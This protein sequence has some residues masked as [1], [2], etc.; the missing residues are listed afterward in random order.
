MKTHH[1]LL[2]LALSPLCLAAASAGAVEILNHGAPNVPANRIVGAWTTEAAVRPCGSNLPLS[3]ARNTIL[4]HA[5]GTVLAMPQMAPAAGFP[6]VAGIPGTHQRG[7]DLGT[8]SY[9]PRTH[10]YTLKLRFDWYVDGLYHG[11]AAVDRTILLSNDGKRAFGP[12]R[13]TRYTAA[14]ALIGAVCGDAVSTRM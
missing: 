11:Y 13:V 14:G 7:P 2:A 6:N 8:W 1:A 4:F 9:N 12:V 10:Q 5:G 3:P